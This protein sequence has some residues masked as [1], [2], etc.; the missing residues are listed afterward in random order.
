[1]KN[2]LRSSLLLLLIPL[3]SFA[4]A[5]P[6]KPT[7]VSPPWLMTS[8]N[9]MLMLFNLKAADVQKL[10]PDGV[11]AKVNDS[12]LTTAGFEMYETN[13]T[14]GIPSYVTAF[15]FVEIEGP[16][17]TSGIPG[18][19]ALWG[20]MND[21]A[22]LAAFQQQFGFPY[23]LDP[24]LTVGITEGSHF[25]RVGVPGAEVLKIKISP[26]AEPGNSVEGAVDMVGKTA[27]GTLVRTE[28]PWFTTLQ[29]GELVTFEIEPRGNPVLQLV[30]EAQPVFVAAST[31]QTFSYSRP[32]R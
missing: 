7:P 10:L 6:T 5:A 23:E 21:P 32:V 8:G 31:K 30:K 15:I 19:W 1:M 3:M 4:Q 2:M 22:A 13:R 12:G 29:R 11:T 28:V 14:Y 24:H 18:H 26:L 27:A 25:G 16:V 9:F 17:S 20:K